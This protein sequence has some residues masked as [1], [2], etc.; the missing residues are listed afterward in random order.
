MR[1]VH[2]GTASPY[3]VLIGEN[4]L[5]QAGELCARVVPPCKAA[6]VTDDTVAGLYLEPMMASLAASGYAPVSFRFAS[7]EES[8]NIRTLSGILEFLAEN[9]LTRSDLVIALGGGV[10]GDIAG[11]AASVYLRGVRFIQI[12][13]TLLAQ[14]DSSVGGKTAID[15]RAGKNL[16]GAFYQP[17]LVLCDVAALRTLP[18]RQFSAGMAEVVKDATIFDRAL[19]DEIGSG[20]YDIA[21]V[22]ERC[23]QLKRDVV[24]RDEFDRGERQLLNFGHTIGHGIE[25]L[26]G[27]RILH[28]EAVGIGMAVCARAAWRMGWSGWNLSVD[29]IHTLEQYNLPTR[30][31]YAPAQLAVA[32]LV[33]KKRRG[34]SITLV[35]PEEIGHCVMK[36][37]PV[38]ELERFI[39]LGA[40]E[41]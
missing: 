33:D 10:V 12:P 41:E 1:T 2:I 31:E 7:G 36:E 18:P 16:A 25:R 29:I 14:V 9:Q 38:S 34:G 4:I 13:T 15:L 40:A 5:P 3:D 23:V 27:Y 6:V 30:C 26:S 22:V 19:F 17:S 8:K 39:E 24:V 20:E 32:C 11:F 21:D 28:G 37:I 35:V